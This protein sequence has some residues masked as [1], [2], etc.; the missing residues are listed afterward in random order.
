MRTEANRPRHA[1]ALAKFLLI[2]LALLLLMVL[3]NRLDGHHNVRVKALFAGDLAPWTNALPAM[4]LMLALLGLTRKLALS[5]WLSVLGTALL[6]GISALKMAA[7]ANPLT[8]QDFM[9]IGQIG[10]DSSLFMRYL[11]WSGGLV[12]LLLAALLVTWALAAWEPPLLHPRKHLRLSVAGISVALLISLAG[13]LAPWRSIY[14]SGTLDYRPWESAATQSR[15]QG[16]VGNLMMAGLYAP[17]AVA[18]ISNPAPGKTLFAA[19]QEAVGQLMQESPAGVR[20]DI[21]VLQSESFFD[22]AIMHGYR[23]ADWVPSLRRLQDLGQHGDMRVPTFGGGTIRTEF[24]VLTGL[25]LQFF[26]QLNYPYLGLKDAHIPGLVHTLKSAGYST[27]AIHPNKGGFWNRISVF[28]RM[29]FDRFID[30]DSPAFAHA[31]KRGYYT[32]DEDLTNVIL[33]DLKPSG[34]PQFI[35]AISMENHGPYRNIPI[36]P[37]RIAERNA[38]PVPKG[39]DP[40][41]ARM[42]RDYLLHQRDAD[43]ELG[44][45]ANALAKRDRPALL[46]FYGDHLPGLE[47]GYAEGFRNGKPAYQQAVPYLLISPGQPQTATQQDLP[48]WALGAEILQRAG[49]HDDA[50]FD[51]QQVLEP[52]LRAADWQLDHTLTRQMASLANLRLHNKMPAVEGGQ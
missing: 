21:I 5:I 51:L 4:M 40:A 10:G 32:S 1:R 26:P 31:T 6:Y 7:L 11:P 9:L 48:A 3:C 20:P 50:W 27:L 16:M 38:I 23:A 33:E 19:H 2:L 35:F 44:R 39:V 17:S 13:G 43:R 36:N 30:S 49:V 45:L 42:L 14:A 8:R 46:V 15:R 47:D 22:P 52:Q 29:G 37:D 41:G 25:P 28:R 24:E 34:P 18:M 12:F